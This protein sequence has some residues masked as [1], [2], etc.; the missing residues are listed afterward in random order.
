MAYLKKYSLLTVLAAILLCTI[1]MPVWSVI[2]K[3][4]MIQSYDQWQ[5]DIDI[6][7]PPKQ[8]TV[9]LPGDKE[10][11]RFWYLM[12]K[13]TNNTG[14]D[15][16][17]YPQISLY[18]NTFKFYNSEVNERRPVFQA[19]QKLYTK[20]VPLLESQTQLTGKILQG[21][22]NARDG[23]AIFGDFDS[24]ATGV[25]VFFAGLSNETVVVDNPLK[26][27]NNLLLQKTL[28]LEY[29]IPGDKFNQGKKVMLNNRRR[30]IMR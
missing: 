27:G 25:S 15:V 18:T 26:S 10:P 9:Q 14:E 11:K 21:P 3:P 20:T 19:I 2:H 23:V 17:Y 29:R 5:L 16:D 28:M 30:W 1:C 7:G 8:I 12:Y 24:I 13:I 22:D 6:L 4:A